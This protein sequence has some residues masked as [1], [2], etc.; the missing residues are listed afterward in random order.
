MNLKEFGYYADKKTQKI[1]NVFENIGRKNSSN[2][3]TLLLTG[4]SGT[5]KTYLAEC[6][7]KAI[8]AKLLMVQCYPGMTAD[9]FIAEPNIAAI[10][11]KDSQ[12]AIKDGLLVKAIKETTDGPTVVLI[13][14]IDKA[15]DETDSF[16]LD[17]INSGRVTNGQ[18][19]WNKGSGNIWVFITSNNK[20][21]L[22]AAFLSTESRYSWD[23]PTEHDWVEEDYCD[24][25]RERVY[26]LVEYDDDDDDYD[27]YDYRYLK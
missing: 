17:F 2:I 6:F 26:D 5:G 20:R 19:E 18:D 25:P 3:P 7:A 1:I 10:I 27:D 22:S 4:D 13:D 9:N 12:N 15:N 21:E 16:L 23:D 11:K 14:E 24:Y 8:G